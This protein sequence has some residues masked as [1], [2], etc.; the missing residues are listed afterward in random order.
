MPD[1]RFSNIS[2][3]AAG[4]GFSPI[5][6]GFSKDTSDKKVNL[7]AGVYRD[8]NE[9]P[10]LLPVVKKIEESLIQDPK[11]DHEYLPVDGLASFVSLARDLL[12]DLK[13]D[14]S[15]ISRIASVQTVS[16][17]GANHLAARFLTETLKP[18]HVWFP[19]PTWANHKLLWSLVGDVQQS[20]YPYFDPVT[21]DIRFDNLIATLEK[22]A[23]AGDVIVLHACAHNPTG[24]DPSKSQW[25]KIADLCE[26]KQLFPL[27]DCAY[28]GFATG[29][30]D[31][32]AWAIRHFFRRG[33]LEIGIA[34]SF[35]K[36]FG[37]YGERVGALHLVTNS[38][39]AAAKSRVQLMMLQGGEISTPPA[40]G[41]KIVAKV[42]GDAEL[43]LEWQADLTTMTSRLKDMRHALYDE[44][45]K[46][47][48]PGTWD[49]L[50]SQ[51][52]MFSYSG[53]TKVQVEALGIKHHI[54]A[55]STGRISI[56][57]LT[58]KNVSYV[59]AAIDSVVRD[60]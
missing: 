37:L 16:G 41:A 39:Q 60:G 22:E 7:G 15:L 57:G 36:N 1:S 29:D 20:F 25:E 8:D 56:G 14:A 46:L 50:V 31:E 3:L 4:E 53:L 59:A 5:G 32:D 12:L 54:Y 11:R 27:F 48:T 51:I 44:L 47:G 6:A 30:I 52:G 49:H 42:L 58:T 35:S 40:Y 2:V 43:R 9:L 45:V 10:W 19:D 24:V 13:D 17:T 23:T 21:R 33:T 26:R 18:Q 34:Q 55:Y 28:Q 38:P